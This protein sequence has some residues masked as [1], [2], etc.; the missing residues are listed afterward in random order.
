MSATLA[1]DPARP[2]TRKDFLGHPK[3]VYVCFFTEMWERFSFYGMKALLLLY[4]LKHH[5]FGDDAGYDLIGAYGG[6]VYAVPVIGGMIA[7]R[8]LGM[9]KSVV[10]G[11]VLLCLGHLGMAV[12]G[13][14]ARMINGVMVRDET[15]L[16]VFYLSLALIVMG[17]GFLKPNISTIVGKLYAED[18]PRRDSGFTVFY[19]GINIGGLFAGLVCAFLGETYGWKYGFGAAGVGM[20]A[21]LAM[22]LWGQRYLHGHAEP[23]DPAKLRDSVGG[24]RREFW[25]YL[26]TFAGVALIWQLIQRNWTVQGAMHLVALAFGL[27]FVW[28]LIR[29]CSKV[30]RQQMIA[31]LVMIL[32]V[33]VFFTLYEQSYGS[34][35]TFTDRLMTKDMFP[36]LVSDASGTLPWSLFVMAASPIL[37]VIALRASD[38]GDRTRA[39]AMVWLLVIGMAVA[40]FRDVVLVPQTAG[41]LTFLG[42]FFIVLLSPLFAWLWPWLERRGRNPSKPFK[43]GIGLLFAGLSFLPLLFA[44][45]TAGTGVP[46]SVWWL[47]LAYL[48]LEIGE[49]CL[50]PIGLSAVTQLSVARVVGLMMGGFWL[51]TAYSEL[52]AAQFGKLAS[53]EVPEGTTMNIAEAA[54]K[55]AHLFSLM[56][57]I[58]L[59]CAVVAFTIAPLLRRMMHGVK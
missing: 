22:F 45:Q 42:S 31:L 30:E 4:L 15:A 50:S 49:M 44:A 56:L 14:Q 39:L 6:L 43:S 36:S 23:P 11:G 13:E 12:E 35:V 28:F 18:D 5:G 16:Q 1:S 54:S 24:L 27:W 8:W 26:G 40:C 33:L 51:A 20:V 10:L 34:W 47:V 19:A 29:H 53:I 38:R 9:R 52:L 55:Y 59:G 46:A 3:G 37:M 21:G 58:G 41:S 25:I 17:V 7:D 32:A 57:W 48:L 2:N